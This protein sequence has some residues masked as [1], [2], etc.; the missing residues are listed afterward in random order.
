MPTGGRAPVPDVAMTAVP[1]RGF[2]LIELLITVVVIGVLAGIAIP[3]LNGS[4]RKAYIATM[5]SDLRNLVSAEEVFYSDSSRYT[6]QIANLNVRPSTDVALAIVAGPGYW[7]ASATHAR[8]TDG[9]RCGIAV[10]T[11][12][13]VAPGTADGLPACASSTSGATAK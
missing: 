10:N 6:E 12:N 2:T 13:V 7:S 11:D 3:K 9:F 4:R 8:I 5:Q 1:R